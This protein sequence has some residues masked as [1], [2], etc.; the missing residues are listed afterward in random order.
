MRVS[1]IGTG[2]VG[3]VTGACLAD[4][5]HHVV[6]VDS[7]ASKVESITRAVS[8]FH[9]PGLDA[10]LTK[11]SGK[12]LHATTNLEEAVLDSELTLIATGTPF[13]GKT[14]DLTAVKQATRQIGAALK[15]KRPYHVVVV[16]STVVPGTTD[17]VVLPILEEYSRKK[18][19][20]DF[21]VGMNPEFLS[22]GQAIDD[23]MFPDRI[24]CGG[25]DART[26]AAIDELYSSFKDC[27]RL[28]TGNATAEFIKYTSNSLL[29]TMIS[30]ANEI[31]NLCATVPGVDAMEVMRGLHLAREFTFV[32]PHGKRS[33]AGISSFLSPG[34]GFGGSCFPKDVK[35]LSSWGNET[36]Q[37]TSLLN[38][39]LRVNA[40]QPGR[41]IAKVESTL[42][43]LQGK[44][45]AV[46]GLAFK[47]GTDDVRESP[48]FPIIDQLLA[49]GAIIRAFDPI[50]NR[51]ANAV[52]GAR[53]VQICDSLQS[54]LEN[55]NAVI[56]VT[57]W[58]EFRVLPRLLRAMNP[59]P[60][61]MD[62]RRMLDKS[63]YTPYLG[64]G[65]G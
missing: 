20:T 56:V 12:S 62:T 28:H 45:V 3:L 25:I 60:L 49:R 35:A 29:A 6:C 23:F 63:S 22:E 47:P 44:N 17:R 11:H 4:R 19:G 57:R 54:A 2:Y 59:R 61:L 26:I 41:V 27:P 37:E 18:A 43:S 65:L 34:C 24:V 55:A 46:L 51:A 53:K 14:I 48:A 32:D 16:K 39:V 5:G 40:E 15:K 58:P 13:D 50:A 8:P 9:E 38:A 30:F 42:G 64:V 31:A 1:I 10:L 21:G 7:D 33:T 36:G 52:M